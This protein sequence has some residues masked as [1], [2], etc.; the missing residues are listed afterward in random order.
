MKMRGT[1]HVESSTTAAML[2]TGGSVNLGY[3]YEM[4]AEMEEMMVVVEEEE[5]KEEEEEEEEIV[6]RGAY[7]VPRLLMMKVVT[8]TGTRSGRS[9]R[10]IS[11][12]CNSLHEFSHSPAPMRTMHNT[13]VRCTSSKP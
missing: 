10:T 11:I 9:D 2:S 7:L 5:E 12:L 13:C 3:G 1:L 4:V 8:V 6:R